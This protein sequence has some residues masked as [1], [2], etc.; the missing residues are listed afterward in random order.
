M[1]AAALAAY[2]RG[3]VQNA[4]PLLAGLVQHYPKNFEVTETLGLIYAERGD[5]NRALPLLETAC[6]ANV[7]SPEAAANLGSVYLRLKRVPEAL[8]SLR[9]AV[10]LNPKNGQTQSSYGQALM[11]AKRPQEAATAF[12]AADK[13]DP[14]NVDVLYNWA[15]AAFSAGD[16]HQ[17]ETTLT[18]IPVS[19]RSA[20][21]ES[22]Y[23]DVEE[24]LGHF[25]AALAC[26][27]SAAKSDPSES[28]LNTLGAELL[29]HWSFDA[30]IKVYEYG[31]S[32][33]PSSARL[34][35]GLGIAR[36]GNN[37]F[38]EAALVFSHLAASNPNDAR[39]TKLLGWSCT[40]IKDG[41]RESCQSLLNYAQTH[42]DNVSADEAAAAIILE[43]HDA[44]RFQLARK[45]L[46]KAM[47]IEPQSA[48]VYYRIGVLD[49]EQEK[50]E[51]SISML[52]RSA[53]LRPNYSRVHL[54]LALAYSHLDSKGNAHQEADLQ[55]KIRS[56]EDADM[57]ARRRDIKTFVLDMK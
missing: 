45:L 34:Q 46:E 49:Q 57:E 16:A 52:K 55:R 33:Y 44:E 27:Q 47:L 50:W 12:Q 24:K 56:A 54:R 20:Q 22:L 28:N 39:Y 18:G 26:F 37:Q 1:L 53:A 43:Q 8:A 3:E 17:A 23:G 48:E 25:D 10:A 14:R 38:Q 40:A 51:E 4:E 19:S 32:Q 15:L 2:S 30:A 5:F 36:Y 29:K 6:R 13:A 11:L 35:Y 41:S 9:R 21:V 31:V 7:S 42:P